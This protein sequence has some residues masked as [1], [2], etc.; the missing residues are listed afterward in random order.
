MS[1]KEKKAKSGARKALK[2]KLLERLSLTQK[3]CLIC[4]FFCICFAIVLGL[5]IREQTEDIKRATRQLQS[6]EYQR[7]LMQLLHYISDHQLTAQ[8]YLHGDSSL[9][10]VLTHLQQRAN[11]AFNSLEEIDKELG[12]ELFPTAASRRD[13]SEGQVTPATA[14]ALWKELEA[15]VQSLD[16]EE[17]A[18]LHAQVFGKLRI[19]LSLL[20]DSVVLGHGQ[21]SASFHMTESM[22]L[23]DPELIQQLLAIGVLSEDVAAA[24]A[25]TPSPTPVEVSEEGVTE[26][27]ATPPHSALSESKRDSIV[28]YLALI[29]RQID[30]ITGSL[31][32]AAQARKENSNDLV[33]K[34]ALEGPL[35]ELSAA[36]A[37]LL[38]S[39]KKNILK[40]ATIT[41]P[42]ATF[43]VAVQRAVDE[44]FQLPEVGTEQLHR[45]FLEQRDDLINERLWCVLLTCSLAFF[46]IV[47]SFILLRSVVTPLQRLSHTAQAL[48]QG[49][50]TSR[51]PIARLDEL[52]QA[53]QSVNLLGSALEDILSNL[54]SAG[55][56]LTTSATEISAAAKEQE[57]YVVQQE[58]A[59]K[60]I[61][62][63]AKQ[64]SD[65]A[66]DFADHI[67]EVA[68]S[69]EETSSLAAVGKESLSHLK[70]IMAQL[71]NATTDIAEKLSTLNEKTGV[72]TGVIT[73]ITKVADR[74]NLLSLNAAIEAHKF[75]AKGGSFGVIAREIRRLADQTAY[76]TLDIEKVVHQMI[77][78]VSTSVEGVAKFSQEI[79][80]GVEQANEISRLL[81]RIIGQV[82]Q[83]STNFESVNQGMEV[84]TTG[85]QQIT[86][87]IDELSDAAQESTSSIRQFHT[88]LHHLGAAI[89]ELQGLV[90]LV[91]C[92]VP[93]PKERHSKPKEPSKEPAGELVTH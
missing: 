16:P 41:T 58:T 62:L 14:L 17:S 67:H 39:I 10:N 2:L 23:Q 42:A 54:K 87:S 34:A 73:T 78:A 5:M 92:P 20:A 3:F 59:T 66:S 15:S 13:W 61:A 50:M 25:A 64:I 74:T 12:K 75:G 82:Q 37:N 70:Q 1:R 35:G 22:F 51:I 49:D 32:K 89:R 80:Q 86:D 31:W 29:E 9:E 40:A 91:Q 36:V 77:A 65:T 71:V 44:A 57:I 30:R 47:C 79:C 84:Q 46:G 76:A 55:V 63:T 27:I 56:Q 26:S 24:S 28:S 60:Q 72:I 43:G 53:S 90:T 45:L 69:S 19:L 6:I 88:S 38:A 21:G 93:P 83:Q 52:G 81:N 48:A 68:R 11:E 4:A 85:A 33:L 8:R 18:A 7:P